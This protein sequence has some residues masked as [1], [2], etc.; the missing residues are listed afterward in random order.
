MA[1]I[2]MFVIRFRHR[3]NRMKS[4]LQN[5]VLSMNFV[6]TLTGYCYSIHFFKILVYV[7]LT[8][9]IIYLRNH[10]HHCKKG[11]NKP[12]NEFRGNFF[13]LLVIKIRSF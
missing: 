11:V 7:L 1:K 3:K 8:F 5:Y 9:V 6:V 4:L 2:E 12:N 10:K 13:T